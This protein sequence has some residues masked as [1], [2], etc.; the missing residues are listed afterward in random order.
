MKVLIIDDSSNHRFLHK[1]HLDLVPKNIQYLEADNGESGL[2]KAEIFKKEIDLIVLDL[3]MPG[4][5]GFQFIEKYREDGNEIPILVI[6]SMK[7]GGIGKA[8]AL[9]ATQTLYK[10]YTVDD[11]V[12][13][14]S[15]LTEKR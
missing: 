14:V 10:P 7:V 9:G 4:F 2:K 6:T 3:N 13:K 8:I 11:F 5:D 12:K 1:Q 15:L